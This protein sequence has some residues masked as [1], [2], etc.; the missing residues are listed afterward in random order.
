MFQLFLKSKKAIILSATVAA[1]SVAVLVGGIIAGQNKKTRFLANG[2]VMQVETSEDSQAVANQVRFAS[3]TA[4]NKK[5]SSKITF[6]SEEGQTA[7]SGADA[8]IHYEDGSLT[9]AYGMTLTDLA[10]F[11][12]GLMDS[13]YLDGMMVLENGGSA[14]YTIQN[15]TEKMA[16]DN[17]LLK[18]GDQKY[19]CV[20]PTLTLERS[21]SGSDTIENGYLELTYID[22][23]GMVLNATDG[24]NAWQFLADS[25]TITFANGA[26]LDLGRM[27]LTSGTTD[28]E[29]GAAIA[30]LKLTGISVSADVGIVVANNTATS[31]T[32]PTFVNHAIDGKDGADGVQG[33][34]GEIGDDGEDGDVGQDGVAGEAGATGTDG[35]NGGT[36]GNGQKGAAG[37]DGNNIDD[38]NR[39]LA[40]SPFVN[41]TSWDQTTGSIA[42]TV[43]AF[44]TELIQTSTTEAYVLNTATGAT[45]LVQPTGMELTELG[46]DDASTK[47]WTVDG[48]EPGTEYKLVISAKVLKSQDDTNGDNYAKSIL[49]SRVFTTDE[50]G[51]Y[52][53]KIK[54]DYITAKNINQYD[55]TKAQPDTA[56][57]G[58]KVT[59]SGNQQLDSISEATI[60]YIDKDNKR[61]TL[62]DKDN[63]LSS[64]TE[65]DALA[66]TAEGGMY[67]LYNLKSDTEYT[68]TATAK[69][70]NGKISHFTETYKTL[71]A[72]PEVSSVVFDINAGRFFVSRVTL[73]KDEDNALVS[74]DHEIYKYDDPT[75]NLTGD[76]LKKKTTTE[77][78]TYFYL[79]DVIK[80]GKD[81]ALGTYYKYG[82]RV[83][84]TWYDNEKYV[85]QEV[86]RSSV[87]MAR[88]IAD[89]SSSYVD[90]R[91][92]TITDSSIKADLYISPGSGKYIYVGY[93]DIHRILV[94]ITASGYTK[95]LYYSNLADWYDSDGN[96]LKADKTSASGEIHTPLE[97]TG[98]ARGTTYTITVMGYLNTW[99]GESQTIGTTLFKTTTTTP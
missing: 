41:V 44:N 6:K 25:S 92:D 51:F 38:E 10:R 90:L 63:Q 4:M 76:C 33:Q 80:A 23:D 31:W 60:S 56:C 88:Y 34:D 20:S 64:Q 43:K 53:K 5:A 21:N 30:S 55:D 47:T 97:L 2:Y 99:S 3:G 54:A 85:T 98:L 96:K 65:R 94:Q 40:D 27:E 46:D 45:Y 29:T 13:Y 89:S 52:I 78:T 84:M 95:V 50:N 42:F 83:F 14:S 58:L 39:E 35:G 79:S 28:S 62:P 15:N 81:T 1:L 8:F 86:P 66:A 11:P 74:F 26:V 69:L 48:L 18:T 32:P 71:K 91:N 37:Q 68:I 12:E 16:F 24:T 67:V 59:L 73:T 82:N 22:E 7:E 9:S 57:L 77:T 19:L 17:F 36:G 75:Q 70:T 61:V 49:V 72:T 87:W 93:K